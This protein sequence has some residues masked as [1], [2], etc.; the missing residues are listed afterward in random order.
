MRTILCP[1]GGRYRITDRDQ[2]RHLRTK[3]HK[4]Y[5]NEL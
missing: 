2:S 3:M 4:R 5:M 1:C